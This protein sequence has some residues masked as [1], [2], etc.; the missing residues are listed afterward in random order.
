MLLATVEGRKEGG[1]RR[2]EAGSRRTA[3]AMLERV[4][5]TTARVTA[6]SSCVFL[7]LCGWHYMG[8]CYAVI[9]YRSARLTDK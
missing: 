5:R 2:E 8:V 3:E 1:R 7:G 4:V 9:I 6:A